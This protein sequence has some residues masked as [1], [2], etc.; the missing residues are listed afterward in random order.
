M[1]HKVINLGILFHDNVTNII[2]MKVKTEWRDL[3]VGLLAYLVYLI[4]PVL[5]NH[6]TIFIECRNIAPLSL[7]RKPIVR[8]VGPIASFEISLIVLDIPQEVE[9]CQSVG[10]SHFFCFSFF[11]DKPI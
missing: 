9:N 2:S 10:I 4:K 5:E 3:F 11:Q 8:R 6:F 1:L 7:I